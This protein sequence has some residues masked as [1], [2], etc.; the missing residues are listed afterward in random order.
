VRFKS[1]NPVPR[2]Q[3]RVGIM[4]MCLRELINPIPRL[5]SREGCLCKRKSATWWFV[6]SG[7]V[8]IEATTW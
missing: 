7:K 1:M 2:L 3:G 6:E 4:K 8:E 5:P